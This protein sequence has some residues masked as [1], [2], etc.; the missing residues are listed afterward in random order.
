MRKD[1]DEVEE[2]EEHDNTGLEWIAL[3]NVGWG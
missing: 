2:I 3:R 1:L